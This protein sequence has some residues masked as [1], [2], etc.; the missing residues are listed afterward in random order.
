[1]AN[2]TVLFTVLPRGLSVNP[3]RFS[4]SV[5]VSPRL[6]GAS[7]LE[8][9]P[10]WLDW[11]QQLTERGMKLAFRCGAQTQSLEID[12]MVLRP[13]LWRAMFK[14]DTF[15]RSHAFNDYSDRAIF[16]YPVRLALSTIKA[17]YQEASVALGLP[18]RES[19]QTGEDGKQRYS[20]NRE[21]VKRLL[22][23]LR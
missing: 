23:G 17:A 7:K 16:S 20:P 12:R 4:V 3:T 1:M 10:D 11:T 9:F 8:Q 5:Y 14:R 15:V 13:D 19:P 18:Q 6:Q 2:Q 22:A 21:F